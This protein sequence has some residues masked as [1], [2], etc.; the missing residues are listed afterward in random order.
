MVTMT[1]GQAQ[2][3]G[4]FASSPLPQVVVKGMGEDECLT[5]VAVVA[6]ARTVLSL[7]VCISAAC[8]TCAFHQS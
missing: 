2:R 1:A 3:E 7:F 4:S 6:A 5:L 8:L